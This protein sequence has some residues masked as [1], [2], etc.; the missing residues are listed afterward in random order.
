MTSINMMVQRKARTGYIIADQAHTCP[1]EGTLLRVA[2]KIIFGT[3]PRF[4]WALG[5]CGNVAPEVLLEEVGKDSP[6]SAKQLERRLPNAIRRAVSVAASA[7]GVPP[8]QVIIQVVGV[9]WNFHESRPEGFVISSARNTLLNQKTDPYVW[10]E[11]NWML[12]HHLAP[13]NALGRPVDLTDPEDFNPEIDGITILR[14]Q[15]RVPSVEIDPTIAPGHCRIGGEVDLV[16][17]T[18]H[19]VQVWKLHD[20]CDPIGQRITVGG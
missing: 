6:R 11:T 10:Y 13:E 20:F 5:V 16:E 2:P 17:V 7:R 9:L 12:G 1:A 18:R 4:P 8:S 14:S 19:G 15:R 3:S